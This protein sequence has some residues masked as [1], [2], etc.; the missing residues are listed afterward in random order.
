MFWTQ[1]RAWPEN[2]TPNFYHK[3]MK[4]G[5]LFNANCSL[6]APHSMRNFVNRLIRFV[7]L[8][9]KRELGPAV[10]RGSL[11]EPPLLL[12]PT[13]MLELPPTADAARN[14]E[15][16]GRC[17]CSSTDFSASSLARWAC[18]AAANLQRGRMRRTR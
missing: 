11:A 10:P 12:P 18:S 13:A 1:P 16:A 9:M 6:F 15:D 17:C 2:I 8:R 14:L 5:V 7:S 4:Y 3:R